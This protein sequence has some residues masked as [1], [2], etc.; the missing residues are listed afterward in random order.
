MPQSKKRLSNIYVCGKKSKGHILPATELLIS[1]AVTFEV[2]PHSVYFLTEAFNYTSGAWFKFIIINDNIISENTNGNAKNN[3]IYRMFV[4]NGSGINRHSVIFINALAYILSTRG[5]GNYPNSKYYR[6]MKAYN[7]IISCKDS[8]KGYLSC[9]DKILRSKCILNQEI[10]KHFKCMQVVSAGSGSVFETNDGHYN[11]CLNTKSGHYR[12]SLKDVDF[13]KSFLKDI[14]EKMDC[15][16]LRDKIKVSSQYKSSKQTIRKV[17]GDHTESKIGIC[18][19]KK[20]KS[21]KIKN[22]MSIPD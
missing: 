4:C 11:I 18:I 12:P 17:F 15:K 3:G 1:S 21:R 20:N 10:K 5:L 13:A 22:I 7:D 14:I 6:F 2:T 16:L 9:K 8:K 19:P